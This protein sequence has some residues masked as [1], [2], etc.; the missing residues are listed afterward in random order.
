[1]TQRLNGSAALAGAL[2]L[3]VEDDF[4][5]SLELQSILS[6]AGAQVVGPTR[7]VEGGLALVSDKLSAAIL[8][9]RL[10]KTAVTPVAQRL[11]ASGIPFLFYTGQTRDDPT[12]SD[13]PAAVVIAKPALPRILVSELSKLLTSRVAA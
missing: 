8:D 6:D 13:W 7:S 2:I 10:G 4:L 3:I 12:L 1:M 11:A 9:L 5:I